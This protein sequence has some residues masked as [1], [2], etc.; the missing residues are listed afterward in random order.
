MSH[1]LIGVFTTF[2][3][4]TNPMQNPIGLV[5]DALFN[6]FV[7]KPSVARL[8]AQIAGPISREVTRRT[9]VIYFGANERK[10]LIPS[11]GRR[12]GEVRGRTSLY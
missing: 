7:V 5:N 12:Q 3:T 8:W 10:H 11:S 9:G 6:L 1:K 4:L 2:E